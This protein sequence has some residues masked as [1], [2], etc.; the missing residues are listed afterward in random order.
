MSDPTG[1]AI[2]IKF[3]LDVA[4]ECFKQLNWTEKKEIFG[5]DC[6]QNKM[7][8]VSKVIECLDKYLKL[9]DSL[10]EAID[11]SFEKPVITYKDSD[12]FETDGQ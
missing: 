4:Y 7:Y 12:G 11:N 10:N 8:E 6:M 5:S 3:G 1:N 9:Q 2:Y